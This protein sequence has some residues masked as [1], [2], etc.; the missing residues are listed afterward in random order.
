MTEQRK[1]FQTEVRQVLDLVIHSLYSHADIFLRELISNASDAIDRARFEAVSNKEIAEPTGGWKIQLVA[2]PKARTLVLRDN[3]V[4]MSAEELDKNLG[5][6]ASSGTKRFLEEARK[7]AAAGTPELIGQFGVGFYSAFMVADRVTVLT[8]RVGQDRAFKWESTGDGSY[9]VADAE[10]PDAG[11]E[12]TLHLKEDKAEY[13]G[14]WKIQELVR[15]YSNYIAFP[16]E[17]SEV[18]E[19]TP[20]PAEGEKKDEEPAEDQGPEVLNSTKAI[21]VRGKNEVTEAEYLEFYKAQFHDYRDPLQTIPFSAEGATEFRALLFIPS[22]AP[23]DVF[24]DP[25]NRGLH[26]YV[27]R[28]FIMN[29]CADLIP[30]WMR[31]LKGVVDSADLPLNVS[32]EIL[33]DSAL[34]RRIQKSLVSRVLSELRDLKEKNAEKYL[35]FHTQFG[36]LLREGVHADHGNAD[37]LKDLLMFE[38][39]AGAAG[40]PVF[41]KDYADR[42]QPDQKAIYYLSASS[43]AAAEAS[44]LLEPFKAR[45][46]EVLFFTDAAD[47][48]IIPDL[49]EYAGKKF[50]SVQE[51]AADLDSAEEKQAKE[52]ARKEASTTHADLLKR[53]GELLKD[54][55][56]EVRLSDRLTDSPCCLVADGGMG[57]HM[58]RMMR[59][60]GGMGMDM[61]MFKR[62]LELNPTHPVLGVLAKHFQANP[63][64]T[65]LADYAALL[66]DQALLL[67]GSPAKEPARFARLVSQLMVKAG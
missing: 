63:E 42:L 6:I 43:R 28:V 40:K 41:L 38:T 60:Q 44:P 48:Y 26:L 47:E 56:R 58:E 59:M 62:S 5:T 23:W 54:D 52:T 20:P 9:T 31:F 39:S 30:A 46:L 12:I 10:K 18:K 65:E 3:G 4:G 32:R 55:V 33:Q 13:A 61:P 2:D 14:R 53:L 45:K 16:I 67:E 36:R 8:R 50:V 7:A 64:A 51:G 11:T 22:H 15:K 57:P 27:K 37:K 17:L 19:P 34:V 29:N 21:W 25:E 66:R 35:N 1:I 24:T 49:G